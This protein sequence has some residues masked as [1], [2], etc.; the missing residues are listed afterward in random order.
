MK[1]L[2][3][4]GN[5]PTGGYIQVHKMEILK[6]L[7]LVHCTAT[8]VNKDLPWQKKHCS[9]SQNFMIQFAW[10]FYCLPTT[11]KYDH[12]WL[13]QTDP[14]RCQLFEEKLSPKEKLF[15]HSWTLFADIPT[16]HYWNFSTFSPFIP[17]STFR[18]PVFEMFG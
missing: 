2:Q 13:P 14:P 16:F 1:S 5:R 18:N 8:A 9:G 4:H 6:P 12:T 7:D 15:P 10:V 3:I 17:L 11:Q